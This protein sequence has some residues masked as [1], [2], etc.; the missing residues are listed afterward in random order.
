[1]T[2]RKSPGEAPFHLRFWGVRGSIP[3]PFPNHLG[4]GGNTTCMQVLSEAGG[5]DQSPDRSEDVLIFDAGTGIRALGSEI[6]ARPKPP[7]TIHIFFSHFHWDHLQGLPYFLPLF[8][9]DSNLVF[10]S[11]HPPEMLRAVIAAQMQAP[12]FP[13]LFDQLPSH[14]EFRAIGAEPQRFGSFTVEAFPLHHPQGSVGYRIV[15]THLTAVF[16][17]DHE[18]GDPA[19]DRGLIAMSR[20]ADVLVYDAQYTPAEYESRRGW[21]HSTW[22]EAV[23]VAQRA[24]VKQLVLFHHDPDRDDQGVRRIEEE[25]RKKLPRTFAAYEGLIF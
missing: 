8:S 20:G 21:G 2:L 9:P 15:E 1:M 24:G 13:F 22:L 5:P 25:A 11:A 18:H 6:A 19:I 17:P 12:Y 23:R 4:I 7:G 14:M 16:A 10:H 3:T